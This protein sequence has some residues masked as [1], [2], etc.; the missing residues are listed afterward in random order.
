MIERDARTALCD[1][2]QPNQ[3]C[4][5]RGVGG[6]W[7]DVLSCNPSHDLVQS[8]KAHAQRVRAVAFGLGTDHLRQKFDSSSSR[9]GSSRSRRDR[10]DAG[11]ALSGSGVGVDRGDDG[12][13]TGGVTGR[14]AG[15]GWLPLTTV[16]ASQVVIGTAE[17]SPMLPTKV[18]TISVATISLFATVPSDCEESSRSSRSG[19]AAPAYATRACSSLTRCGPD[20]CV[21]RHGRASSCPLRDRPCAA[22]RSRPLAS[23]SRRRGHRARRSRRPRGTDH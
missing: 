7:R 15:W 17:T 14:E 10:R 8:P 18:R 23:P 20:R 6:V 9:S 21:T 13:V 2:T 11:G 22:R 12:S 1:Y 4:G 19:S 16:A 3:G 5:C